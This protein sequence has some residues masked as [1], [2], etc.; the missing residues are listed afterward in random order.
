MR[1]LILLLIFLAAALSLTAIERIRGG[2]DVVAKSSILEWIQ[3]PAAIRHVGKY[4]RTY[5][6]WITADGKIQMRYFDHED[7]KFSQTETID[8]LYQDFGVEAQDDHNAPSILVLPDGKIQIFYVVHDTKGAFFSRTT[9][10]S[11]DIRSWSARKK[12]SDE[13]KSHY[14]YPQAKLLAGGDIVL[15]YRRG[16]HYDGDEYF[17][18]SHDFGET[19][20]TP[21]KLIEFKKG[22]IYAFAEVKDNELHVAFNQSLTDPPKEDIYYIRSLDGGTTWQR[23]NGTT[24]ELPVREESIDRV[25][26]SG[27]NP[28]FVWD[29][30]VNDENEPFILFA[31]AND[32]N[33]EFLIAKKRERGWVI[34]KITDS[35]LLYDNG[36]FFSGGAVFDKKNPYRVFLSK[37][38]EKLEIES[39]ESFD[40]GKSWQKTKSIT[41]KSAVDNFRPQVVENYTS[42][43]RLIWSSGI[44]EGLVDG[45]W[46]GYD[47]VVIKSE[48]KN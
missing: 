19:W 47:K 20:E 39:W 14:N 1:V 12:M 8:D 5:I 36:H 35:A 11:E 23:G 6:S 40:E 9:T 29:I 22:G 17:K 41:E 10:Q 18:I 30:V 25:Y 2:D 45:Q 28:S 27:T 13:D 34:N 24:V 38:R 44:Y 21:V 48:I 42:D 3:K 4:D 33:H 31:H 46:R 15:F 26:E 43:L 37:K 32:P 7:K 16:T